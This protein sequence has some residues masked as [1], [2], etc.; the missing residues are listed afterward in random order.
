MAATSRATPTTE[1]AS[2]RL[3]VISISKIVSSSP[4]YRSSGAPSG[5]SAGSSRMPLPSTPMPSSSSEQS[6]PSESVPRILVALIVRP[7]GKV[8][9]GGAKAERRPGAALGAPQTTE[10]RLSGRATRQRRLCC[11]AGVTP[12]SCSMASISPMTTPDRPSTRGWRAA[13]SM[14]ALTR[15]SAT[16]AGGRSVSTNSRSQRYETFRA[17]PSPRPD[18]ELREEAHVVLEEQTDVVDLVL[19]NGHPLHAH[20]EGP[21]RDL[22]GIVAHVAQDVRVHHA[23]AQNLDPA[24]MLA[25]PAARAAALEA[26]HVHLRGRFREGEERGTEAYARARPEH[27]AGEVIQSPLEI[28]HGDVAIHGEAF[29]LVEHGRV[30]GVGEVVPEDF[31][32][33]DDAHGRPLRLH[34]ADLHGRGVGA[35]HDI[36]GHME[37]VLHVARGMVVGKVER[38]EVVVVRLHLGPLRH[39][40]SEP[41]EDSDDLFLHA[42]DRMHGAR[43]GEPAGQG[44]V[45]VARGEGLAMLLRLEAL[46]PRGERLLYLRLGEIRLLADAG[47]IGGG[48]LAEAAQQRRQLARASEHAHPHLLEGRRG[49]GPGDVRQGPVEDVLDP[50]VRR[51][52]LALLG[53]RHRGELGE[54]GRIRHGQLGEDLPI[55]VDPSLLEPGHEDGVGQPELAARRV[56]TH[57]PERS[58]PTLLLLPAL[59]GEGTRAEDCLRRGA[60]ELAAATEV[61]LRLL[62]D[63]LPA[64]AGLGPALGPWH[65]AFSFAL[66]VRDEPPERRLVR[67]RDQRR[68]AELAPPL[69]ALALELV[70][71]PSAL[72]LELA[73]RRGLHP[74]G[75]GP[76]RLHLRHVGAPF[77][78]ISLC[79]WERDGVRAGV[80]ASSAQSATPPHPNPLPLK[81]GEGITVASAAW[82]TGSWRA[83]AL[84]SADGSRLPPR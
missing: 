64:L 66:Q 43:R 27:L 46:V 65:C 17:V 11:P 84:P 15:R 55:E 25:E 3:G 50:R 1:S 80:R 59:V 45:D 7:P 24:S 16:T 33:A 10:K 38:A 60:V 63:L 44:E 23:G 18:G 62:E 20:A 4:R 68:L 58:R 12:R 31:A 76:L 2:G 14:P 48:H 56:D 32:G 34:G 67:F 77:L 36:G 54:G 51:H 26:E 42:D 5:A 74:L 28:G 71:L 39:G 37:G 57:D 30:G 61:P 81:G 49:S 8:A 52:R 13:T 75:R 29:D 19:E 69:G 53:G 72:A 70:A 35:Q 47:P 40:E 22:L 21:A 73:A 9:P 79:L 41:L 82:A 6:M 78:L 83:S